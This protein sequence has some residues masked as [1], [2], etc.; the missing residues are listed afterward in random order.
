[1]KRIL[2]SLTALTVLVSSLLIIPLGQANAVF[3]S[4]RII[5]DNVFNDVSATTPQQID[6]FLNT[7]PNS[8]ISPN[9][10][11]SAPNP[12][13]YSPSS[14]YKFGGNTSAG[15]VIYNAAKAYDLNPRVLLVTLQKEQSLVRGDAGCST[16]RYT[17]AVGY[18]CPDGGSSYN[19]SGLNLYTINGNTVTSVSG[20]CVNSSAKAGFSQQVIRAAWLLKFGQQRSL[21]NYNWAIIR[22]DWDNSDDSTSC[23]SGPMTQGM[24][25]ICP[26]GSEAYYDGYRTIDGSSTHMDSGATAALYWYTPHFHGNQLFSDIWEN[27]FGEGTTRMSSFAWQNAGLKVMD[28]GKNV[29]IPTDAMHSGERLFVQVA[30]INTGGVTWNRDG[31]NPTRLGTWYERDHMTPY[32]DITWSQCNRTTPLTEATVAP[33]ETGHF[34]FYMAVPNDVG[35]FREYF[36]PVLEYQSWT[37]N[38]TGFNIFVRDNSRYQWQ[39]LYYNAWTDSGKTTPVDVSNLT[40][41]QQFYVELKVKNMSA[42]IWKNDGANPAKLG[43]Y[44]AY[45]RSS[46]FYTNSWSS[47]NRPTV[48]SES[49]VAPGQVATFGFTAQAPN[50]TGEYRE[51]VKPVLEYKGW[52]ADDLNHLYFKVTH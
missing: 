20:T 49:T 52:M 40:K 25:R 16:L 42:T 9:R 45:D 5:D 39:W 23:Y 6:T 31:P 1:M 41:G 13:G 4:N 24:R 12:I 11:F 21:G 22:G 35:D 47:P 44:R 2:T 30:A 29:E 17:G 34:E 33:G 27:W 19:Y 3:N 51:Y 48:M 7:F 32:C 8:C 26:S 28:E 18:G 50:N 38:D 14:G 37:T 15:N 36:R 10:G 46:A 43:T